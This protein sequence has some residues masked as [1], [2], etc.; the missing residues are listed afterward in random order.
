[1]PSPRQRLARSYYTASR[2]L[3][4]SSLVLFGRANTVEPSHSKTSLQPQV[5]RKVTYTAVNMSGLFGLGRKN[6]AENE[7]ESATGTGTGT[8]TSTGVTSGNNTG[9]CSHAIYAACLSAPPFVT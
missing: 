5:S 6:K 8:G 4:Y 2:A 1:M 3:P 7:V 9:T